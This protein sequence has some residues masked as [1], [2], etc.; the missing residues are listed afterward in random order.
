[1]HPRL[2]AMRPEG[3]Y[4][5]IMMAA[6]FHTASPELC[7]CRSR[8][9]HVGAASATL[10][11]LTWIHLHLSKST[12]EMHGR[13]YGHPGPNFLYPVLPRVQPDAYR[14]TL[15]DLHVVSRR[16]FCG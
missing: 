13:F 11:C 1:V 14:K 6:P 5:R 7:A 3:P 2:N 12:L 8:S 15:D 10:F 9:N 4:L 16:V